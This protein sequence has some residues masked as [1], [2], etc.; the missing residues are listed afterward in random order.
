MSVG[1]TLEMVAVILLYTEVTSGR[2]T[3]LM[4][5]FNLSG[6][7]RKQ[8]AGFDEI[9]T[10]ANMPPFIQNGD[11]EAANYPVCGLLMVHFFLH[12]PDHFYVIAIHYHF[13]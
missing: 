3:Q 6:T 9:N 12:C 13:T 4:N 2:S 11:S 8:Y 5:L 10:Q 1:S 7:S